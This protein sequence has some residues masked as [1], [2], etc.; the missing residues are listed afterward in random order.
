MK[1]IT[2]WPQL[3]LGLNFNW[4]ALIG[5]TAVTGALGLAAGAALSR[6]HLLDARLRHDLRPSGQGGRRPRSASNPRPWRSGAKTRPLLF[7]FYGAA[8]AL[9]AAA[10]SAAGLGA[11]FWVGLVVGGAAARLAGGAGRHRRSGR[12]PRQ[13]P[14]E[15]A[16]RLAAARRHRRRPPD[17]DQPMDPA[18][19]VRRNTAI[20]APPLVPEIRLHLAT[21]V[22]PIWQAT[23]ESLARGAVPPPFWAFAWAGGQALAR[24]LLDHPG[25]VA[26]RA[27]LDFGSGSG[28]VAIAAA[29][30]G[31]RRVRRRRDRPF[32]RRRDRPQRGAQRR[33]GR[34]ETADLARQRRRRLG[35]SSPPATSAT[36]EPMAERVVAWLRALAGTRRAGAARRSRPRLSAER[37]AVE[38]AR[39]LVPTS[40]EL[41]DRDSRETVVWRGAAGLTE[42]CRGMRHGTPTVG[43]RW[44]GI[45]HLL[46]PSHETATRRRFGLCAVIAAP[47]WA[48]IPALGPP[49]KPRTPVR[50][51]GHEPGS[52]QQ[53]QTFVKEGGRRQPRRGRCRKPRDGK[54]R[55]AGGQRIR[56]LDV[57]RSRI[58][59]QQLAQ[60]IM[61]AE[62]QP[63]SADPDRRAAANATKTRRP[64]WPAI[65]PGIHSSSGHRSRKDHPDLRDGSARRPESD[66][67]ELCA[68]HGSGVCSSISR[69]QRSLAGET[70]AA[71]A[72]QRAS[73]RRLD[74]A[75]RSAFL[76]LQRCYDSGSR[77]KRRSDRHA[78]FARCRRRRS[79]S[80]DVAAPI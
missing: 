77:S 54:G 51:Y 58:G 75:L 74:P 57:Y 1:R 72:R 78:D 19:F 3:F 65:R 71:A 32:R 7:V 10:G 12:L 42:Q 69:R 4:G 63:F 48:Q 67:Q 49:P 64:E 45:F 59:R 23:E 52:S 44:P 76:T 35:R 13:I 22:T 28:L 31:A 8:V 17:R 55:H 80:A 9:W 46:E 29:K 25:D 56:P 6:R 62:H 21:E 5:W 41:E 14:L 30:A 27:V 36:S 79:P 60:A 47:A 73:D 53:D 38:L 50:S 20:A 66:D 24:Y 33:R 70:A 18:V 37:R 16:R 61:A 68:E 26:G 11:L 15:P 43:G 2:Y 40:R 39:Y 34:V